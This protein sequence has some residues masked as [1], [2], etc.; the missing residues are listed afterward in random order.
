VTALP[1]SATAIQLQ[2]ASV[3]GAAGYNVYRST[4]AAPPWKV[5][6]SPNG[7]QA[8]AYTD[9]ALIAGTTYYYRVAAI[10]GGDDVF[11][12]DVVSATT[13]VDTPSAPVLISATGSGTSVDLTWSDVDG[14][15]GYQIQLSPD[16]TNGW[17]T[18]GTQGIGVTSYTDT[19]LAPATT[20]YYRVVAMTSDGGSSPPSGVLPATTDAGVPPTSAPNAAQSDALNGP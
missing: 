3:S 7:E 13:H 6:A 11:R 4:D 14:E 2:W 12:S 8:T 5:V 15:S 9:V 18:I 19:G 17:S 20:Y 1:T 10:V 16:G